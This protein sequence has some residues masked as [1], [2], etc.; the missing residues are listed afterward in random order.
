MQAI[1]ASI[2]V[3]AAAIMITGGGHIQHGD[4]QT[5]VSIVGYL[6]GAFALF[7]WW[8]LLVEASIRAD[9]VGDV[10]Q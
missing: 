2:V 3:L 4:T 5:A 1:S 6:V 9:E 7:K 10:D 8:T